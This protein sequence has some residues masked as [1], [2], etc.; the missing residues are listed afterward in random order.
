MSVIVTVVEA[1]ASLERCLHGLAAQ[2]DP[3]SMQVLVP[4]DHLTPDVGSLSEH[5]PD[6]DFID[7]G[8]ILDGLTPKNALEEHWFFDT[9]RSAALKLAR[10]RL[11]SILEDRGVPANDW[12]RSFV[13]MHEQFPKHAAI[14]GAVENGAQGILHWAGFI[15]NFG[16]YQPPLSVD[17]PEFLS[18]TNVCYKREALQS[19]SEYWAEQP[20]DEAQVNWALREKGFELMLRDA[21]RTVQIREP[22]SFLN[23]AR[24]RYHWGRNFGQSRVR[25]KGF[26]SR[27]K[28]CLPMPLMPFFLYFRHLWRQVGKGNLSRFLIASP[29]L[30]YLLFFWSLG[31][32]VGYIEGTAKGRPKEHPE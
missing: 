5:F 28:F 30:I 7:L 2:I 15:C 24:E 25:N 3:P 13:K 1:G 18:D 17:D 19:V 10:G 12:A 23:M 20:F 14:G 21:P 22:M 9:R 32:F 6:F 31:E 4:Y 8:N 29:A 16:R 26:G 27:L 11:I